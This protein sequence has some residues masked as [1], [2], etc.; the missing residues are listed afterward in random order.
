MLRGGGDRGGRRDGGRH[1]RAAK[2]QEN[3]CTWGPPH[4]R[5]HLKM[6][7]WKLERAVPTWHPGQACQRNVSNMLI[8]TGDV[9]CER[10]GVSS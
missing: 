4:A 9:E 7:E 6:S 5:K 2:A 8:P 3:T 10:Q 1:V